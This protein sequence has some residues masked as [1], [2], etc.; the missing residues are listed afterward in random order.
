MTGMPAWGPN[1]PDENLWEIV[2]F[3]R[4]LPSLSFEDFQVMEQKVAM[5]SDESH[6]T[7]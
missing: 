1:A 3:L 4:K 2:A 7:K 5:Q 6:S